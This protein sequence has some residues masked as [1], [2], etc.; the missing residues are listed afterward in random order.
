VIVEPLELRTAL[1]GASQDAGL[2]ANSFVVWIVDARCPA[3][4]TPMAYL[5][6]AG[7]VRSDTVQVFRAVGEERAGAFAGSAHRLAVWREL[8]GVPGA[9]LGT[10]LR[11]ELAHAARWEWSGAAFYEADDRLRAGLDGASYAQLPTEREANASAASYA[12]RTLSAAELAELAARPELTGLLA[13]EP[14]ADVVRE[15]LALLGHD[16]VV[17]RGA[18]AGP[19]AGLRLEV[20]APLP[21]ASGGM[22]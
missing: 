18:L 11:H 19:V 12:R 10:M 6:P 3:G 5:Q 16:V 13:A 9:A 20:I 22:S 21:A 4:A 7:C 2:D 8:P 1:L 14:P 17:A 15:T